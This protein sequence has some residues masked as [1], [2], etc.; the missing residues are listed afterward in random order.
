MINWYREFA[1]TRTGQISRA[2]YCRTGDLS[3]FEASTRWLDHERPERINAEV[4][5]GSADGRVGW[6]RLCVKVINAIFP[7]CLGGLK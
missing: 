1:R 2:L 7:A 5:T 4:R 3:E 6:L